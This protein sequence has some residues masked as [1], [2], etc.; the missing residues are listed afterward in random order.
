MA[1]RHIAIVGAGPGGLTCGMILAH[2]GFRVTIFERRDR[3]GGRNSPLE[4]AGYSFDLGP[5]FL[6]MRFIL[7]EMF[8]Q[9]GRDSEDY[10]QFDWLDPMYRLAF[11]EFE[12]DISPDNR[13]LK[14]AIRRH[15]PG[16]EDGLDE[17]MERE[18][19]RFQRLYPCLQKPYSSFKEFFAPVFLKAAP[20]LSLSRSVFQ[21]VQRYFEDERLSL[22]FTFQAKYL[23]MSPWNCPGA[24][25]IL[26][27]IEHAYGIY[28][29]R[30]GLWKISEAMAGVVEE[31]GAQLRLETPVEKLVTENG[32]VRGVRLADGQ[33]VEADEV[34]LNADFG[35]AMHD[36]VEEGLLSKWSPE[37][38]DRTPLSCSTF[39]LY[40][41]LD[42]EYD[43]PH[44]NIVF[45]DD[46]RRNLQDVF[47][48]KVL[49]DDLSF[50]IRNATVTD[51]T[52]APDGHSAVYV[53]VPVPNN[54][55]DIDWEQRRDDFR[56][57][58]L[59]RMEG[60]G[61]MPGLRDHIRFER[62]ITPDQ[63]ESDYRVYRG[64]VFNL[65]HNLMHLMYFR[66]HNRFEELGHCYLV[67]GGTHPGSGLPTIYES[68]RI[69]ANM[70]SRV[71]GLEFAPPEP[72]PSTG[73]PRSA[74][75]RAAV[76][77]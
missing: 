58:V 63:W 40:L 4:E 7:D 62:V 33:V 74:V 25:T 66:P 3:V 22:C 36:L 31:E 69:T 67:G 59:D 41:G 15:F 60:R 44:H 26:P 28:H 54:R 9:V 5:T 57:L 48:R 76:S 49:S 29:V 6:M 10:L 14:E 24:F 30:G 19:V 18:A 71:Y 73:S 68:G 21:N 35:Y 37:K 2:R 64:A 13:K 47:D 42:R 46:Y 72:L 65:A 50:Y 70:I 8:R 45:A 52:L 32:A 53:L 23:G 11:P 16:R 75:P 39:M 17:F 34:V 56:E 12:L 38:L 1:D 55:S 61:G 51:P 27:Y 43:I 20:H 77:T